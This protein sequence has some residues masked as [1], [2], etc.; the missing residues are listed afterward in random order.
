MKPSS[1]RATVPPLLVLLG[2][3]VVFVAAM[4]CVMSVVV[5]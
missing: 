1:N 3:F 2:A 5:R 4:S